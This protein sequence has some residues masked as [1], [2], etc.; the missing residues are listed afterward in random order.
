MMNKFIF[1]IVLFCTNILYANTVAIDD[2][3]D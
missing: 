1:T 2:T 3:T